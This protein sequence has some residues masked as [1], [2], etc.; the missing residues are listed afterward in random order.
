MQWP[1]LK[2]N[3]NFV[4]KGGYFEYQ[5]KVKFGELVAWSGGSKGATGAGNSLGPHLHLTVK[6]GG[7]NVQPFFYIDDY[8]GT[9]Y[10]K[11][12]KGRNLG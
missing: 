6:K 2:N 7:K 12:P 10:K 3:S 5:R 9:E 8:L 11:Q 4:D 1:D